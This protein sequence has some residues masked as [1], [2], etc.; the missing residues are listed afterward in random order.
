LWGFTGAALSALI[1][2]LVTA[3]AH[4][5]QAQQVS[6]RFAQGTHLFRRILSD[7]KLH[8]LTSFEQLR[9]EPASKLL[10]VL[11]ETGTLNSRRNFLDRLVADGGAVLLPTD[12]KCDE[13]LK[14]FEVGVL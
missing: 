2:L 3:P 14:P 1:I 4:P 6:E 9:K 13:V 7:L 5:L 10:M 8:P 12:R 11:G